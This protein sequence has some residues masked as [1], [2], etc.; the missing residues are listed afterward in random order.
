A[1]GDLCSSGGGCSR[2]ASLVLSIEPTAVLT[3]GDNAYPNGSAENYANY[4]APNWG[5][6]LTI[7]HP[8][9]GNHD[10]H[11]D[12][13]AGYF[14]YFGA[15]AGPA[16]RGYYS[17]D[18]GSWHLISLDSE[19]SHGSGSA[20]EVWLRQ[21]LAAT[22]QPCTLAYWHRPRFS[23]SAVHGSD[24]SFAPFWRDL[25][26]ANAEI[27]LGGHDHLYE[28]FAPQTASGAADSGRGIR[29]FVVGTG[30][31]PLYSFASP[32]PNSQARDNGHLGVLKLILRPS[33]Y[34]WE[35]IAV[36][37]SV[38]DSGRAACH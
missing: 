17:Y 35:F 28:R 33:S 31:A 4:Y 22:R 38:I 20:Q 23:S 6:F 16:G 36:G 25:Y 27:A 37:G 19:L 12:G 15:L 11:V 5:K 3:L 8:S 34:E 29:Q 7:T 32:L 10:H 13:A 9:P 18:L 24:S 1:A 2:T 26:D 30:G 21:D 14:G